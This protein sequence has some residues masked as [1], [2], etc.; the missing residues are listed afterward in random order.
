MSIFLLHQTHTQTRSPSATLIPSQQPPA[1]KTTHLSIGN[2]SASNNTTDLHRLN[3]TPWAASRANRASRASQAN[4][5]LV[6]VHARSSTTGTSAST[7]ASR[8]C[9]PSTVIPKPAKGR[10]ARTGAG[11]VTRRRRKLRYPGDAVRT[12]LRSI[13]FTIDAGE[14][15]GGGGGFD[16]REEARGGGR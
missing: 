7:M 3:N 4:P 11:A 10:A 1:S 9:M 8:R 14:G 12:G 16:G 6:H 15:G 2:I 13:E 5:A